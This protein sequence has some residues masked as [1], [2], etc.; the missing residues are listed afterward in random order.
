[1]FEKREIIYK[2]YSYDRKSDPANVNT[3]HSVFIF[4][5]LALLYITNYCKA[6]T[7][8]II[9]N[10]SISPDTVAAGLR[11]Y[12][13]QKEDKMNPAYLIKHPFPFHYLP[14][15]NT[16]YYYFDTTFKVHK[17][18]FT[19]GMRNDYDMYTAGN[20]FGEQSHAEFASNCMAKFVNGIHFLIDKYEYNKLKDFDDVIFQSI[21]NMIKSIAVII[22]TEQLDLFPEIKPM[23]KEKLGVIEYRKT[24]YK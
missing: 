7:L 16:P 6:L 22:D 10:S 13:N 8:Q 3:A 18:L 19:E 11:H 14:E 4:N 23:H 17:F 1:M 24:I 15:N 20:C 5:I 12:I 9:L 2:S 21:D